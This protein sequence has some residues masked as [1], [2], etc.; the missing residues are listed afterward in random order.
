MAAKI[1][2]GGSCGDCGSCSES[3][4]SSGGDC[5]GYGGGTFYRKKQKK[6]EDFFVPEAKY[7][8]AGD[9]QLNLTLDSFNNLF[10]VEMADE[11]AACAFHEGFGM[12]S[13]AI[14]HATVSYQQILKNEPTTSNYLVVVEGRPVTVVTSLKPVTVQPCPEFN[15]I[16]NIG[17]LVE[18]ACID[19]NY[20]TFGARP[21]AR[22]CLASLIRFIRNRN[23]EVFLDSV[24]KR[25]REQIS[26]LGIG[27]NLISEDVKA[28]YQL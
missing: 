28:F 24:A 10:S 19:G 8:T 16:S 5:S 13:E 14:P 2:N 25:L 4:G 15:K 12:W 18:D 26:V 11:I 21:A 6:P 20:W 3:C 23:Q 22:E 9:T 17:T 7:I 1:Y 27:K